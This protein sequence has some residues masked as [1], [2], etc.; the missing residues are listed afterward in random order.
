MRWP[1]SEA[2]K[3]ALP[4]LS[5]A[6]LIDSSVKVLKA[7]THWHQ[8][9][10]MLSYFQTFFFRQLFQMSSH[11]RQQFV[12]AAAETFG[13]FSTE[14]REAAAETLAG[15]IRCSPVKEQAELINR[16]Q[17]QF[18]QSLISH[19]IVRR[20]GIPRNAEERRLM[21]GTSTPTSEVQT[22]SIK[23]HAAVL[24]S[25]CLGYCIPHTSHPHPNGFPR[26]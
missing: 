9:I 2:L 25:W 4:T 22:V 26:F 12:M 8:R 23:R 14:V 20:P 1:C 3:P 5:L 17:R 21:S 6:V 10:A 15:M 16:L 19:K 24:E 7:A 13:R 11:Q 18:R